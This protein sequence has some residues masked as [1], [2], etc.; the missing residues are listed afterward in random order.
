MLLTSPRPQVTLGRLPTGDAGTRATLNIMA[1][2]VRR[3]K[4]HYPIRALA[5][6]LVKRTEQ[7]DWHSE[8][9]RLHGYVR[10]RI[11]YVRDIHGVET[12]ATPD[13]TLEAGQGDCDDKSTLLAALLESI[14]HP[15]RFVAVAVGP[16]PQFCH[17]YVETQVG[18][19]WIP[20]ET[21]ESWPAGVAV[22]NATR[23]LVVNTG[24]HKP[25]HPNRIGFTR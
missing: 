2:L 25:V 14:G 11:R 16:R 17:V 6:S 5:L 13:R 12:L 10:D 22:P 24:T 9:A 1:A 21:T 8:V 19:G 20:L 7:K 4:K 3:Y 18:P 15:T 23:R